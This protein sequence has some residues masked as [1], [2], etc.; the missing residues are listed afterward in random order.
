MTETTN[1]NVADCDKHCDDFVE[2]T[3]K[4]F[5]ELDKRFDDFVQITNK[6]YANVETSLVAIIIVQVVQLVIILIKPF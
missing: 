2:T 6:H 1:K 4:H 5:A 3:N